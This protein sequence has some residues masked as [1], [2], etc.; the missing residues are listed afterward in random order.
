MKRLT[1]EGDAYYVTTWFDGKMVAWREPI[2]DPFIYHRIETKLGWRDRLRVLLN[3][4]VLTEVTVD[5]APEVVSGVMRLCRTD[6]GEIVLE[7]SIER[8]DAGVSR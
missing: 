1:E 3:G 5:A 6:L 2:P 8:G 4:T 7:P